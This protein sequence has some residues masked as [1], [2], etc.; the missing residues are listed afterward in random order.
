MAHPFQPFV[1]RP[2]A[3]PSPIRDRDTSESL[4]ELDLKSF[5]CV[6]DILRGRPQI[7]ENAVKLIRLERVGGP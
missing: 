3:Q 1:Q 6:Y 4:F 5:L 7:K 2:P